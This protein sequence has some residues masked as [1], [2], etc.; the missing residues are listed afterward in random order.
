MII[1]VVFQR[2]Y[3]VY[4]ANYT[5]IHRLCTTLWLY[6]IAKMCAFI[7]KMTV[8]NVYCPVDIVFAMRNEST[9]MVNN[10]KIQLLYVYLF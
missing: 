8:Q 9:T 4:Y 7:E 2:L 5:E 3:E 6:V 1:C 10:K